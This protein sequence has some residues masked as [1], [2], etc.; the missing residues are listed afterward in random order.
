MMS[1]QK[2][3][4]FDSG[5]LYRL[6]VLV[7]QETQITFE[8]ITDAK[9]ERFTTSSHVASAKVV[10]QIRFSCSY[11]IAKPWL[12][13]TAFRG[14][15]IVIAGHFASHAGATVLEA[16]GEINNCKGNSRTLMRSPRLFVPRDDR[17]KNVWHVL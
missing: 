17:V 13:A 1:F 14:E 9:I 11:F 6:R 10:T 12:G 8:I 4:E 5:I 15:S 7:F 3:L 16:F 2:F